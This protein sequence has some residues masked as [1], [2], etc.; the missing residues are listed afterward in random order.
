MSTSKAVVAGIRRSVGAA[1][2]DRRPDASPLLSVDRWHL[3]NAAARGLG[4]FWSRTL[5]RR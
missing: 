4:K 1:A 2:V 3:T 5:L